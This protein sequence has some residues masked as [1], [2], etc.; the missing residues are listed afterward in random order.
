MKTPP[1]AQ[2]WINAYGDYLFSIAMLKTRDKTLAED[3]VQETFLSAIKG[4]GNFQGKS[5]E[6][7]WLVTI[8]KNKII[9]HYRKKDILK[10]AGLYLNQTDHSF[11]DH[12]FSNDQERQGHWLEKA[13]PQTWEL[14]ADHSLIEKE[15]GAALEFCLS[16]LPSKLLPVFMARFLDEEEAENIC[17]E[18]NLSSSNYWVILHRAKLLMRACLEAKW[19]S[20]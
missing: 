7:T 11:Y 13:S 9:D 20:R 10:D 14:S 17:K 12:F 18:F 15:F 5:S 2:E 3:L 16:K 19:L 1:N 4:Y 8:L 6:K